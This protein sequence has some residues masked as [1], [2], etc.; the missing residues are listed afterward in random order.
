MTSVTEIDR[1]V[2]SDDAVAARIWTRLGPRVRTAY[3]NDRDGCVVLRRKVEAGATLP[4]AT[5]VA[6]HRVFTGWARALRTAAGQTPRTATVKPP[7][8]RRAGPGMPAA[9]KTMAT[10]TAPREPAT[11]VATASPLLSRP[12]LATPSLATAAQS[13]GSGGTAVAGGIVLAG[14]IAVAAARRKHA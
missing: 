8:R 14:L 2:V 4:L 1:L 9:A 10:S 6:E 5:L 11:A 12:A 7:V 3:L 13:K